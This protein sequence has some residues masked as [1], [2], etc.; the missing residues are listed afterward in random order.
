MNEEL[1][2]AIEQLRLMP[3]SQRWFI[4][5]IL[6]PCEIPDFQIDSVETF[7]NIQYI[8][9]S[10]DWGNALSQLINALS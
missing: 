1:R 10:Q 7:N 2:L 9:F 4:P 5:L 8:D 3:L 6:K